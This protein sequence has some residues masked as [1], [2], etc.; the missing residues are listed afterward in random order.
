MN[1][2]ERDAIDRVFQ[3]MLRLEPLL[4][5]AEQYPVLRERFHHLMVELKRLADAGAGRSNE[6]LSLDGFHCGSAASSIHSLGCRLRVFNHP[7]GSAQAHER[8]PM[9]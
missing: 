5:P 2:M 6:T 1:Q 3:E 9:P 7:P 8:V 4:P